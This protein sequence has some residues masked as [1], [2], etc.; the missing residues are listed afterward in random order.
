MAEKHD[1]DM[2]VMHY[3]NIDAHGNIVEKEPILLEGEFSGIEMQI[4]HPYW[5]TAPWSY[6]YKTSFLQKVNYPFVEDVLFED[7]DYVN[8]HLYYAKSMMYCSKCAYRMHYNETST[9][10][11]MTYK[12]T[13]D[14]MLLGVRML[15]FYHSLND[16]KSTYAKSILEGGSFNIWMSCKRLLKLLSIKDVIAFYNRID[17]FTNRSLLV[18]YKEPSYCWTMWTKLCIKHKYIATL[19]ITLGQVGYR[20]KR[21]LR[22]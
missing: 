8:V 3:V 17:L 5:G 21:V 9:T 14:Y 11:T 6:I 4:K 7:S 16:T 19:F 20:L 2:V 12:H 22:H 13:S 18:D 1:L 15:N 10:H